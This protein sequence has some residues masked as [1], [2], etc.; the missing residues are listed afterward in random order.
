MR[1]SNTPWTIPSLPFTS[2]F[3]L[4]TH[5]SRSKLGLSS[6]LPKLGA[7]YRGL[8]QSWW[9][10]SYSPFTGIVGELL[11]STFRLAELLHLIHSSGALK[12]QPD[13]QNHWIFSSSKQICLSFVFQWEDSQ[14]W[15][16]DNG[17]SVPFLSV[18]ISPSP[19][20]GVLIQ[21]WLKAKDPTA[22]EHLLSSE[23]HHT[24]VLYY[25]GRFSIPFTQIS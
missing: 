15:Q 6:Q 16:H 12:S 10:V 14:R 2:S 8:N 24:T 4:C 25:P 21:P 18:A 9:E 23:L 1:I 7:R 11:R 19:W 13:N 17:S 3:C 5:I 22:Q 20:A